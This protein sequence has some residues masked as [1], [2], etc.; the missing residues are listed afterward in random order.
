MP[1]SLR[2]RPHPARPPPPAH[3]AAWHPGEQATAGWAAAGADAGGLCLGGR[4]GGGRARLARELYAGVQDAPLLCPHGHIDPSW[5]ADEVRVDRDGTVAGGI[6]H[7]RVLVLTP[8]LTSTPAA[9]ATGIPLVQPDRAA[10]EAR[11]LPGAAD[12]LARGVGGAAGHT[13]AGR[14]RESVGRWVDGG[15]GQWCDML[16]EQ[17]GT[18]M[19]LG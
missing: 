13:A 16:S 17:D 11:S 10:G 14:V 15:G 1:A 6:V 9:R 12:A 4:G 3:S 5:L 18:C 8:F 2:V 19:Q 7:C